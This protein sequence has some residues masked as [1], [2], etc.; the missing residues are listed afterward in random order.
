MHAYASDSRDRKIMPWVL[1]IVAVLIAYGFSALVA[2]WKI[3]VPWWVEAPSIMSVY[4]LGHLLY[5]RLVWRWRLLGR[6]ISGIPDY[7][8]TWFG[9]QTSSY[10]ESVPLGSMMY[11]SQTWTELCV[12]F[13]FQKS[14]SYSLMAVVNVTPGVTEGL[15]F[16]YSNAPRPDAEET[17]HAHIGLSHFRLA[18]DGKSLEGDYFSGRDRQTIGNMKLLYLGAAQMAYEEAEARYAKITSA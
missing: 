17:M 3:D 7:R 16:E 18:P 15:T 2:R 6:Q 10:R 13:V 11:I 12:E 14:R 4:G 5:N 9:V 8:G 1:A